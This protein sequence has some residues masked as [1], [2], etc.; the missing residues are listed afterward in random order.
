MEENNLKTLMDIKEDW[1]PYGGSGR[2][3][4]TDEGDM[5]ELIFNDMRQEAIKWIKAMEKGV[6][7]YC[8]YDGGNL[9]DDQAGEQIIKE[10]GWE[11]K[12]WHDGYLDHADAMMEWIKHFFN[13]TDKELEE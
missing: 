2:W 12:E 3:E 9:T 6:K 13:I 11:Y 1:T 7:T 4:K 5:P 10:T 8:E